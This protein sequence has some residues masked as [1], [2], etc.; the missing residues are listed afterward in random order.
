[1]AQQGHPGT[2]TTLNTSELGKLSGPGGLIG[3]FIQGYEYN[4]VKND[5]MSENVVYGIIID[6]SQMMANLP[7]Q[8]S[9]ERGDK[10]ITFV[11]DFYLCLK[12]TEPD[13]FL[14][15]F[16]NPA[17]TPINI[18]PSEYQIMYVPCNYIQKVYALPEIE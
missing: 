7:Q 12:I 1:M 8:F 9:K 11:M 13:P 4:I 3:S 14:N 10:T 6:K 18:I 2:I 16:A 5:L 15:Y 17:S